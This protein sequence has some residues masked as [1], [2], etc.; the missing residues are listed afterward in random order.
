MRTFL[1]LGF[2][3]IVRLSS[4]Q[5]D[6]TVFLEGEE[7]ANV[8]I[9]LENSSIGYNRTL[10]SD[11]SG[12]VVF[13]AIP[14]ADGYRLFVSDLYYEKST[15]KD[16]YF[17]SLQPASI[18][19]NLVPKNFDL[20]EVVISVAPY[21]V[22]RVNA[23]VS[24]QLKSTDL[25]LLPIEGR[26]IT[27][28]LYRLPNVVQATGFYPE[29]PNVSINGANALFTSYLIDG[30][31]NN[32]RFLGGQKFAIPSG[33]VQN[34]S[35]LSNNFSVEYGNSANGVFNI[36]SAS[37]TNE[38]HGEAYYQVRPGP[39]ID[40]KSRFAQ[41]DLSGNL[42]KDGF[43]R[44][45]FGG[46]VGGAI[47]QNKT[48]YYINAEATIDRKDNL[49]RVPELDI[50]TT[51][52][53]RNNF[54]YL[55]GKI[56]HKWSPQWRSTYRANYG[57]VGIERQGGGLE[58]GITFPSAGNTQR[59]NSLLL[60]NQN[61]YTSD[62]F[63]METNIQY[64]QFGWNYA[65]PKNPDDPQVSLR[66]QSLPIGIIGNPGYSFDS[67]EKTWQAQQKMKWYRDKHLVKLGVEIISSL[68]RLKGG[69][70]PNGAYQVDITA[71][72][73]DEL[74]R[75][76]SELRPEDIPS[77]V[78][79]SAY[80][81]ELR[82]TTFGSRQTIFTA[83]LE[84]QI[85]LT[86]G[87]TMNLGLRYDYDNLSTGGSDQ[88]DLNN[89]APRFAVNYQINSNLSLRLGSGLFYD[90]IN[91][92]VY[93]DALQ[94]NTSSAD[95]QDQL[96]ELMKLGILPNQTNFDQVTFD[97]NVSA[98]LPSTPYLKGPS[99]EELGS[100]RDHAFSNERRILNP[101]GYDNPYAWQN[102][103]GLQYQIDE[104][105]LF[106][107]DLVYN[108]SYNL[109]RL[110]NLNTVSPYDV[111]DHDNLIRTPQ[112]A[113]LTRPI[114]IYTDESGSYALL[115]G[116]KVRG[117]ARNI[118]ITESRGKAEFIGL[119]LNLRKTKL[120]STQF[121][122]FLSYTLS[123][124][125]NDTDDIN[126][127]ASDSNNFDKEW[128]YSINDRRHVLSGIFYYYPIDRL[129]ISVATLQQSGQ[130]INRIPDVSVYGTTDLNGDGQSYGDSYVGNSD[131]HPG[132][133]R[134]SDR[135]PWSSTF[136]IGLQY[137]FSI[138][139]ERGLSLTADI[140]NVFNALNL[141]GYSNNAT[142]SNQIQQGSADS[143]QFVIRNAAP[144]RQFQFSILYSF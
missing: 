61:I 122:Y 69:G 81:I 110:R 87:L 9:S 14:T 70:P 57:L 89:I 35:V 118:V 116:Q 136:D 111:R 112:E 74:Q 121:A 83:Y 75:F 30:M 102:M 78:A 55:S 22:N 101:D 79:V 77:E 97:G 131:R 143:G 10:I 5:V 109:F 54:Q 66:Y 36:T 1:I 65:K 41:R 58:G 34:I 104:N 25:K 96:K 90:K 123:Q 107:S 139:S 108:R 15:I 134:N 20:E 91:Y 71:N 21:E 11:S 49:L 114:P 59:R 103:I 44:H 24:A 93:S 39:A 138:G 48:F 124:L 95:Y 43:Q 8:S 12:K 137:E 100:Q 62:K 18:Q 80:S 132:E 3:F 16:L 38:T 99:P 84:D 27:R 128:G 106:Y 129:S 13:Q 140:F 135:L 28:S 98:Y 33:F 19:L 42:V 73:L 119:T 115:D 60:A 141:S 46:S 53:G 133:A 7:T 29:A 72:Q 63:A 50:N 26:D 51:I 76:G 130:P 117:V 94:Q 56:D 4:A 105:T 126:F 6:L 120:P 32:E 82:P 68:H 67:E 85:T 23:E 86:P 88:G 125:K 31:D 92:A 127:R 37:G 144:P 64:S 47:K 142:Q 45:Q 40:G 17:R 2:L 113:D 52:S